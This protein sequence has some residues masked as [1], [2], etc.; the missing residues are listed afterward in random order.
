VSSARA[1]LPYPFSDAIIPNPSLPPIGAGIAG[2]TLRTAW[3]YWS[4]R[5]VIGRVQDR[6]Q[7]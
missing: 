2:R 1:I 7:S 4:P 6:L 5:M 3:T